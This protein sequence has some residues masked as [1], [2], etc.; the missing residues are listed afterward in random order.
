MTKLETY[1]E[2]LNRMPVDI[3]VEILLANLLESGLSIDDIVV[4]PVGLFRRNF[5][6]DVSKATVLELPRLHQQKLKLEVNRDGLYDSLPEGL[7]HQPTQS[8]A[9]GNKQEILREI[10]RQQERENAARKFFLP[11]EQEYYRLRVKLVQEERKYL[12]DGDT[13]LEGE[14]FSEFWNFPSFLTAQQIHNL[15]Y[16]LPMMHRIAGDWEQIRLSFET[17][18]EDAVQ[19]VPDQPLRHSVAQAGPGLGDA[20]LGVDWVMGE[21]YEEVFSSI[22]IQITPA[23]P[24][25]VHS[26]LP[27]GVGEQVIQYLSQYLLP[28]ETDYQIA[29]KM[30][31]DYQDFS[32]TDESR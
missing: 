9:P 2:Q 3:R 19:I 18:L 20:R 31:G 8:K 21:E 4:S 27:G 28:L 10:K 16:L 22:Q 29:V 12:F 14:V 11:L 17:I 6:N 7:F 23:T 5:Q 1:I 30:P 13:F 25:K 32:V 24:E 15:L 26:Y